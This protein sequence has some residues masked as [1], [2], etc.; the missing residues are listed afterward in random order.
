MAAP[1][2]NIYAVLEGITDQVEELSKQDK[3]SPL[4]VWLLLRQQAEYQLLLLQ[5][6]ID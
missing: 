3:V 1:V 2:S 6:P 5:N 4:L